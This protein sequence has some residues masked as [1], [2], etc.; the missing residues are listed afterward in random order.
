MPYFSQYNSVLLSEN[1]FN[2]PEEHN[3][4]SLKHIFEGKKI[5][6]I[7]HSQGYHK[8]CVLN[9]KYNF[10]K[11]DK[12]VSLEGFSCYL[13]K[14]E[15]M[16][17]IRKFY[18]DFMKY[19]YKLAPQLTL[20]NFMAMCGAPMQALPVNLNQELLLEDLQLLYSGVQPPQ[21]PHL[22]L[23]SYDDWVIPFNIIEDNFRHLPDVKIIY[24]FGSGHLLG[25]K[26]PKYVS[27]EIQKFASL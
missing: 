10:F 13:G 18:L 2:H 17:T 7:G 3:F 19:S 1:Y 4:N 26:F 23:S 27:E 8:L 22:V 5:I 6:G 15:P 24:T 20:S 9:Q 11:L 25:M 14:L 12:I 16:K 21:I